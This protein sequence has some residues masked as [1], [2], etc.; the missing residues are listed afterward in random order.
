MID[1]ETFRREARAW[2]AAH[3]P[4][5]RS[6]PSLDTAEGFE[7]HRAWEAELAADR[8][9]V[10]SWPEEYGGR[11]VGILEWLVFEEEYWR[12]EA[13]LRVSQ[14]GVF[15]LAPT[16]FEFGTPDQQA[17]YLPAMAADPSQIHQV[18]MNLCTSSRTV[19]VPRSSDALIIWKPS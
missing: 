10:V 8:W 11:G 3:T 16:L 7:A 13:P 6:L 15:L 14:N 17:R 19:R 12:A 2:L 18:V 9:S 4:A 5:P 1:V